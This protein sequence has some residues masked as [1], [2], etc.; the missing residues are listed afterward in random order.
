[1]SR[2]LITVADMLGDAQTFRSV[3]DVG[4]DHGYVS[5]YLVLKHVAERALAMDVRPGPLDMARANVS[6]FGLTDS[7]T[8]R[9]SDGLS[10]LSPG[11]ADG[12]VIAGMGGKLMISI[13]DK[14][15]LSDLGIRAAVLQPQSD[16]D[17]FRQYLRDKGYLIRQ[18]R[19]VF[20]DGKYY[21]P[22]RIEVTPPGAEGSGQEAVNR[23]RELLGDISFAG[24]LRICNRYGEHN[25]MRR[26][27]LLKDFLVHG[28][29]V[30]GS[31]LRNLDES[32]HTE[33]LNEV[34]Q[35]LSDIET[36]LK[37]FD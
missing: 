16:I 14:K 7:I 1:M 37:L 24:A 28:R 10:E 25:I 4:C 5:I 23:V 22:I 3:A 11:E 31:I 6:G 27:P 19:I 26:D 36:V 18:E 21:F 13:L 30:C 2:R 15:S 29:E 34:R 33:R 20:E 32:Q 9:L 35:E 8:V 12:L 17:E